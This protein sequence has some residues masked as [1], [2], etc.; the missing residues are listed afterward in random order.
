MKLPGKPSRWL[1][2]SRLAALRQ[3]ARPSDKTVERAVRWLILFAAAV[4]NLVGVAAVIVL[5][6]WVLGT[7]EIQGEGDTVLVNLLAAAVYTAIAIPFGA[8]W[9]LRRTRPGRLWMREGRKPTP[10][11]QRNILRAP[12]QLFFVVA[13]LWLVA[14]V[15]FGVYNTLD[16]VELGRRVSTTIVL[17]G[18]TT[19]ALA[20]LLCELLL[21]PAAAR[22]LAARPLEEPALPGVT[23]RAL[24]AWA[25]GSGIPVFGLC[26]IAISVLVERDFDRNELAVAILAIGGAGLV[27]G[28]LA[29]ALAARVTAAPI[30]SVRGAIAEVEQGD[31]DAEVPVYDGT[32]VGL[33]Q[34]G[35]NRMAAGLRERERMREL[36]GM[37]VGED[38]A[39]AALERGTELGGETREVA[40]LFVD[41]VGSTSIAAE[42]EPSEV[43]DLLNE[44]FAIVVEVVDEHGGWVNKF[45]GDAALAIFGAPESQEDAAG[46]ALAAARA[47]GRRLDDEIENARAG[48]GVSHGKVV[49]G[50]VGSDERFEYTVI[51][52][53]VNEAARLT[54]LAKDQ[55][56][57]TVASGS[58]VGAA[59]AKERLEWE[60]REEVE[61]RGRKRPTRL[62]LPKGAAEEEGASAPAEGAASSG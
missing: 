12:V 50:N 48:I 62:A 24:F 45:E 59:G 16:S 8:W 29:T 21:R 58:A 60:L 54:E 44:F 52:D 47:L 19:C 36:F 18:L 35:F 2:G 26:L 57:R 38:V 51:G 6:V 49:A 22:A 4:A 30:V 55:P 3:I 32:E 31:L 33:L 34:S 28:F 56:G 14:A 27:F 11:E 42:R 10:E 43:V 37:H 5:T 40:V 7:D 15:A 61:L 20:Y 25:L 13:I 46:C 1:A 9:V 41:V 17:A 39:R 23:A 53:P